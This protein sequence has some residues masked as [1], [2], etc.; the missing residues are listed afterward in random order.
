M[1]IPR[2][3]L[4]GIRGLN[5][6]CQ[7]HRWF[8]YVTYIAEHTYIVSL[9]YYL[10]YDVQNPLHRSA[11]AQLRLSSHNLG[12]ET[13]R[14]CRPSMLPEDRICAF[15]PSGQVDDEIHF[16]IHCKAHD[17]LRTTILQTPPARRGGPAR[18][19]CIYRTNVLIRP[20]Q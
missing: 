5:L 14:H 18:L 19:N 16:L 10:L 7:F 2:E 9:E 20:R 3:A 11:L 13:G 17:D 1:W 4:P 15:C 8:G 6:P 12:I